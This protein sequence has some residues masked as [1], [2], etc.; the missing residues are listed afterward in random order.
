MK[1][2]AIIGLSGDS[3]FYSVDRLPKDGE[4]IHANSFYREV[5]GKGF[6][7]AVALARQ[8]IKVYFLSA[9][10]QDEVGK[11]CEEY[12]IQEGVTAV[13]K[14]KDDASA[15][16]TILRSKDGENE[17][18]VYDG[19]NKCLNLCDLEEFYEYIKLSDAILLTCEIPY[20][21]LKQAITYAKRLKKMIIINPAPYV[22]DD[23]SI[24]QDACVICPNKTEVMQMFKLKEFDLD[25]IVKFKQSYRLK[26]IVV[27]LGKEGLAL[28]QDNGFK[29]IPGKNVK[30]IDTTGAG[31][32]FC[33]C[34]TSML[35]EGKDLFSACEYAN[36]EASKS[37][38]K[39]YVLDAIPRRGK[40]EE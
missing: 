30:A 3:L 29:L 25:E 33:A 1:K 39:P 37:V 17:V 4:T 23:M 5:G 19:A 26:D 13:F 36:I 6:N 28:Y 9:V 40:D 14:K 22:Y 24:L 38:C 12:M 16:A 2:V 21:V 15:I 31:D 27:T 35:L 18:I 10:G 8:G 34:M 11:R 32:V 20:D 7:Q